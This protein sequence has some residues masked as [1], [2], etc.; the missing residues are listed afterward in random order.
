MGALSHSRGEMVDG[1]NATPAGLFREVGKLR[2]ASTLVL[3]TDEAKTDVTLGSIQVVGR[4]AANS[5][6]ETLVSSAVFTYFDQG[7][8][9]VREARPLTGLKAVIFWLPLELKSCCV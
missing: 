3:E 8:M 2:E 6:A 9:Q 5:H 7:H 4:G 1:H